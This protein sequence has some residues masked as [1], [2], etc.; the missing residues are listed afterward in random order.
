[1][2]ILITGGAGFIGSYLTNL[3]YNEGHQVFVID[4]LSKQVH[5]KEKTK[6]FLYQTIIDKADFFEEDILTSKSLN[7]LIGKVDCIVHLAAETGTGQSMY[8]ISNY[9]R[10]NSLGTS[11]I[12]ESLVKNKNT[13]KKFILASSRAVYGE[14]KYSCLEHGIVYPV[15]RRIEDMRKGDFECKCPICNNEVTALAT[16]EDSIIF[17]QSIYGITKF[18]QEQLVKSVCNSINLPYSIFRFQNVY[19]NGQSL[20]NPYTGILAIF[21]KLLLENKEINVFEDGLES[22]DFIHVTDITK[23]IY[24]D[25][26]SH[27]NFQTYNVGSGKRTTVIEIVHMLEE[28]IISTAKHRISGAF[29]LGDIRHNYADVTNISKLLGFTQSIKLDDGIFSFIDWTRLS[30]SDPVSN[31]YKKSVAEME[32]FKLYYNKTNS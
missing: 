3:L 7:S 12:L 27:Q 19:G 13:V 20:N 23:A 21:C 6:S 16:D 25:L 4:N 8:D 26:K 11:K 5:G 22:R 2:K 30:E 28:R 1:M 18:N 32:K 10:T 14:G 15:A 9:V 31:N 24:L 29:R 17:P